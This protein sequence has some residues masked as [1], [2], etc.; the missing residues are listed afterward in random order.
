VQAAR[1]ERA[2]ATKATT[3]GKDKWQKS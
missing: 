2:Q 1:E 3:Q